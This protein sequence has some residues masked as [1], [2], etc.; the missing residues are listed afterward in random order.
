MLNRYCFL[1]L[2]LRDRAARCRDTCTATMQTGAI[3]DGELIYVSPPRTPG[4]AETFEPGQV[5][6]IPLD[7]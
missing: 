1:C 3:F 4:P 6:E 2:F 7:R 5:R